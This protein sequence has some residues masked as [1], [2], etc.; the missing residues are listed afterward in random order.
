M[1]VVFVVILRYHLGAV[2]R[3][4][5]RVVFVIGVYHAHIQSHLSCIVGG[6]K[7]LC[8]LLRFRQRHSAQQRRV[9]RLRKF[10]QLFD[11]IFLVRRR[12]YVVQYLI[13]VR[14]VHTHVFRRAVVGYLVVEGGK[15]RHFDKI[16]E[17]LLLHHVVRHV[18]LEVGRLLG[19]NRRPCV[20]APDILPFQFL[21]TQVLEEQIQLRQTVGNGRTGEECRPQVLASTLLYGAY[22]KEHIQGFLASF[23][24]SQ[25]CHAIVTGVECQVLKLVALVNEDMVDAHL[26]EV[27]YVICTRLDGVFHLLQF[28]HKVV[29]ALLQSFQHRPRHVL[30]LLPQDFEV[31]LHRVKL[32]LQDA[33]LQLRRLRNLAELV[34]RHDDAIVVVVLDVVEETHAVGGR[35]ILLGGIENPRVRICRLIGGGNLRDIG[36]QPDNH[37]L[38]RQIQTLHFM[39]CNAHYQRFTGSHVVV[40][41]PAAV[42]F[43]HPDAIHLRRVNTL[44]TPACQSFQIEVGKGLVRAVVL[45]AYETVELAVIHRREPF[46]ELRRLLF[47]P[48]REPVADFVDLGVGELYALAVAHLDVIAMLVLAYGLHHVGTGVVQ[49]M[50]QQVH[51]VIVPV[52]ALH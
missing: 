40:T 46:L 19:E 31:F 16:A 6:D 38:V 42:L 14:T 47:Q 50:F 35:E 20:K 11:E 51:A 44:N 29:L 10:H 1:R 18:E 37:R 22:G 24:V 26:L 8:L 25:A 49:G 39:R 32:R 5:V 2:A 13:L 45:R 17:T 21:R 48:F 36:F 27:H 33:L 28:R 9:A 52:I 4:V 41:D 43:E 12:R 15:L 23:R 34:V 3:L 7:H 30:A